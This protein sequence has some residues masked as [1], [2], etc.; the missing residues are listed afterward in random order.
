M[1]RLYNSNTSHSGIEASA[2][3]KNSRGAERIHDS[4]RARKTIESANRMKPVHAMGVFHDQNG[5]IRASVA[6]SETTM[7]SRPAA[8]DVVKNHLGFVIFVVT[9]YR[10]SRGQGS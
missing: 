1:H 2:S 7:I 6:A 10:G 3:Q 9:F 5:S 8:A 4:P